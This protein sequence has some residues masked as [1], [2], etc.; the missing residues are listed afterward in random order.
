MSAR[1]PLARKRVGRFG[2]PE[3]PCSPRMRSGEGVSAH[4]CP[5]APGA[6]TAFAGACP[7]HRMPVSSRAHA[8]FQR[9]QWIIA[10]SRRTHLR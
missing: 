7:M 4:A 2:R 9:S 10:S 8:R 5:S 1:I 3:T 6:R